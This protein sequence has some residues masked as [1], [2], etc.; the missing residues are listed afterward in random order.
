MP[1]YTKD[2][3]SREVWD[4]SL[5]SRIRQ[6]DVRLHRYDTM[7]SN[8]RI[9][10]LL[11]GIVRRRDMYAERLFA[12]LGEEQRRIVDNMTPAGKVRARACSNRGV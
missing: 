10:K 2:M 6:L 1:P 4:A 7:E 9:V 3:S 5:Q 11:A 8:E 12:N